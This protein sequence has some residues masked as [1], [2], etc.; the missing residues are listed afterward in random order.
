MPGKGRTDAEGRWIGIRTRLG[1][2]TGAQG[3]P[4]P[5]G[6]VREV[7]RGA[8]ADSTDYHEGDLVYRDHGLGGGLVRT[9]ICMETHTSAGDGPTPGGTTYWH[10]VNTSD[11]IIDGS[12]AMLGNLNMNHHSV[13]N[14][15]DVEVEGDANFTGGVGAARIDSPRV[16]DMAGDDADGEGFVQGVN[17]VSFEETHEATLGLESASMPPGE[18]AYH[19]DT[20]ELLF[21]SGASDE[22][23][24]LGWSV[25][26]CI[27]E[28]GGAIPKGCVVEVF[29]ED[30]VDPAAPVRPL[31]RRWQPA[32]AE[33]PVLVSGHR[34]AGITLKSTDSAGGAEPVMVMRRGYAVDVI[35]RPIAETGWVVNAPLWGRDDATYSVT[36]NRPDA[37]GPIVFVGILVNA[38]GEAGPSRAYIDVRVTPGITE[39]SGVL[40]KDPPEDFDVLIYS[41]ANQR[42]EPRR[43][44]LRDLADGRRYAFFMSNG[45]W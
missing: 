42:H 10:E 27:N 32:A 24:P 14:A 41:E 2:I 4:G 15:L 20:G 12:R 38:G 5:A 43:L 29:L 16:I 25:L 22:K 7:W 26:S 21:Q 40:V 17:R 36:P 33:Q 8:W 9:Y 23:T 31:V 11:L 18:I 28:S 1:Q 45:G 34:V 13:D 30:G 39:L 35:A 44:E 6:Q 37:P 3:P 19:G